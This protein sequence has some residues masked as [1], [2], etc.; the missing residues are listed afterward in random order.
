MPIRKT[1]CCDTTLALAYE[2]HYVSSRAAGNMGICAMRTEEENEVRTGQRSG[3]SASSP[4][5]L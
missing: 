5:T 4:R 2:R 1:A 3:C